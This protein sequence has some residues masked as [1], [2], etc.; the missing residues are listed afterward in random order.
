MELHT[1]CPSSTLPCLAQGLLHFCLLFVGNGELSEI[2]RWTVQTLR[3]DSKGISN[4][5][6]R[7]LNQYP[8]LLQSLNLLFLILLCFKGISCLLLRGLLQDCFVRSYS[9]LFTVNKLLG[10]QE[11]KHY[12]Q[13]NVTNIK[14]F[15]M[16]WLRIK[17]IY[18]FRALLAHPQKALYKRHLV[19]CMRVMS[20]G[21]T[22]VGV[23]LQPWCSQLT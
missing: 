14:Q 8:G 6:K 15:L 1:Q 2:V 9:S 21:C 11:E 16:N 4:I 12:I 5:W 23:S 10:V 22:R 7:H 20:V 3:K 13:Y 19:Y 18:M 17:G